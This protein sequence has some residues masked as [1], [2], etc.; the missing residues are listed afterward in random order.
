MAYKEFQGFTKL[1]AADLNT[2][3]MKQSMMVFADA[4][5]RDATLPTG[6]VAEGMVVYMTNLNQ[7][8]ANLNGTTTGWYPVAGQMP[9]WES[10][11]VADQT[12][13]ASSTAT[14]VSYPAGT[15]RN[16]LFSS[17][18]WNTSTNTFTVPATGLYT[19]NASI[20]W[21]QTVSTGNNRLI[22]IYVNGAAL[23]AENSIGTMTIA[24]TQRSI[25]NSI[26]LTAN[27]TIQIQCYQSSGSNMTIYGTNSRSRLTIKYE[28]P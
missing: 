24:F 18:N 11:K 8:Q 9:V 25:L 4:T 23:T 19:I 21:N 7:I 12:G 20:Y 15:I 5:E 3:L 16:G 1:A 17:G 2:Y 27:D 28:G 26:Y 10:I 14:V 22:Y 6:V 13:I